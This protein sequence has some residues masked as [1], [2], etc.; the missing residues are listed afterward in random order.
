MGPISQFN[1]TLS[2]WFN[3]HGI[4]NLEFEEEA[5]FYYTPTSH[6]VYYALLDSPTVDNYFQQ[7]AYEYGAEYDCHPFVFSL[8]H[9]VGHYMTLHYFTEE[10]KE[11]DKAAK[12]QN[13]GKTG[14]DAHYDY[15][16]LP[17]EFAANMWAINW[18]NTHYE[19]LCDLHEVCRL[20]LNAIFDDQDIVEQIMVW[21]DAVSEGYTDMPFIISEDD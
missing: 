18:L 12:V 10:E 20:G 9:E 7:F 1:K 13:R 11:K 21:Q 16:E 2:L 3:A 8:L 5:E 15:W 17:T 14:I 4:S 19:E 6:K